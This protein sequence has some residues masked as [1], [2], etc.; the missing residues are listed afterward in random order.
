MSPREYFDQCKAFWMRNGDS[1]E[2]ASYK[3]LW[4]DCKEVWDI[5][6][7]WNPEKEVFFMAMSMDIPER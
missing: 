7:S 2:D 1:E 4:W 6:K 5:D 3:A